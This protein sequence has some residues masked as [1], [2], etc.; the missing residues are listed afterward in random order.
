MDFLFVTISWIHPLKF[1]PVYLKLPVTTILIIRLQL[2]FYFILL[3]LCFFLI[4]LLFRCGSFSLNLFIY[5]PTPIER[6]NDCF[7]PLDQVFQEVQLGFSETYFSQQKKHILQPYRKLCSNACIQ[8]PM[9]LLVV[10]S[11]TNSSVSEFN[12]IG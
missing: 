6:N 11:E 2:S 4:L 7:F 9:K 5:Q 12:V 1:I 3:F 8:K 10:L